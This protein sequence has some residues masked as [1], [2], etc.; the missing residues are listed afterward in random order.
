MKNLYFKTR[1]VVIAVPSEYG[2]FEKTDLKR[3]I[4]KCDL[5]LLRVFS[6]PVAKALVI[7]LRERKESIVNLKYGQHVLIDLS[8]GITYKLNF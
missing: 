1:K 2:I 6:L 5:I 4:E 7:A 3:C 8:S